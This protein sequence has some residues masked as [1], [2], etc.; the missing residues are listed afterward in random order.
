MKLPLQEV[1][2]TAFVL[3]DSYL[4]YAVCYVPKPVTDSKLRVHRIFPRI[5]FRYGF[6][7]TTGSVTV[8][9]NNF[10]TATSLTESTLKELSE[11]STL[12]I[13]SSDPLIYIIPN[14]LSSNECDLYRQHVHDECSGHDGRNLT[15]SNPPQVSLD[16]K[17][18]WPL[19]FLSLLSGIPPYIHLLESTSD[20]V[21]FRDIAS[22]VLPAVLV[23]LFA[24]GLLGYAIILPLL[25][26]ISDTSSRTSE[27]MALNMEQDLCLIGPLVNRATASVQKSHVPR[28]FSWVNWE[29]PVVTRYDK[30]A[31]FARHGDASPTRGSEWKE[32]GGQRVVTCICYLNTL[33]EGQGGETYFDKL[34]LCIRPQKGTALF[35]YPSY[36]TSMEADE[37]TTHESL[38]PL[39]EKWIVQLFGRADRVPPPL[40]LMKI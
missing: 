4:L 36:A 40:G 2:I 22:T 14:F 30:G 28:S 27:A 11:N 17:K 24:M 25:R 29:A 15:R 31:I 12:Y 39:E 16:A 23:S 1:L 5:P 19:P 9:E 37:R 7:S 3:T 8:I 35:F 32:G 38:P 20:D 18:L 21:V 34:K 10:N 6:L 26:K 13:L 33:A